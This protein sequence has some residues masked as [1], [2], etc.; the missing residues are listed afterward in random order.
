M[1]RLSFATLLSLLSALPLTAAETP[2]KP[3][4]PAE[5]RQFD[6]WLGQWDVTLPDGRKAGSN[7]ITS[8]Y[9]GCAIHEE[10]SGASGVRGGSYSTYDTATGKWHQ[11]WVDSGGTLLMMDGEFRDGR[12]QLEGRGRGKDSAVVDRVTW[13]P[14]SALTVRQFWQ[15]SKDGGATW[16]VVFDGLYT[17]KK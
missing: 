6:F 11:T 17:K 7:V 15:Q 3:C 2:A 13:T 1:R 5:F 10:W 4:A 9:G 12:M 8:V 14:L 16:A